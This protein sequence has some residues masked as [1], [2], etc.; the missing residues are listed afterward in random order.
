[1]GLFGNLFG[2]SDDAGKAIEAGALKI[3]VRSKGEF[4]NGHG[5]GWRNIP[6]DEVRSHA[7]E[8]KKAGKP[9]VLCCASGV[10]SGRATSILKKEG[11]EAYNAGSWKS[12][13]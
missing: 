4:A 5:K 1:M 9:V 12:W 8:L 13:V 2:S 10:R 3:D 6:L 7:A 11:I